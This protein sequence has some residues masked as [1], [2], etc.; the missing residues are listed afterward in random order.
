MASPLSALL[1]I[2]SSNVQTLEAAYAKAGATFPSLDDPFSP[3]PL[4]FDPSL[5]ETKKLIVAA[6]AQ[7]LATVCSPIETLQEYSPGMNWT[8]TLGFVVDTNVPDILYGAGSQ[9][10]IFKY[11]WLPGINSTPLYLY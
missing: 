10:C 6:A 3:T 4:D 2:I 7:L 1:I 8:A 11:L 9:V 5:K